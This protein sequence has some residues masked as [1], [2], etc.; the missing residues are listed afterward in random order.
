M[1]CLC[2]GRRAAAFTAVV[3][4]RVN[5]AELGIPELLLKMFNEPAA[6]NMLYPFS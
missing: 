4:A 2:M 5:Y 1:P 6:I 3:C